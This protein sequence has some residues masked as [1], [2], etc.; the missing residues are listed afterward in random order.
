MNFYD[1]FRTGEMLSRLGSDTQVVQD[2][3]TTAVSSAVKASAICIGSI[4]ILFTYD[5][6]LAL[7]IIVVMAPQIIA[8]RVTSNYLNAF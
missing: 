5:W 3:L 7:I 1:N 2:G 4:I 8:S 6:K